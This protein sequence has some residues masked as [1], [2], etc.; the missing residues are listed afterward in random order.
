MDQP[1]RYVICVLNQGDELT[2]L[3]G[4]IYRVVDPAPNDRPSD[5]RIVDETGEDYLYDRNWFMDMPVPRAV[6]EALEAA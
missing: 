2:V 4:K 1:H 5:I 3:K 6:V